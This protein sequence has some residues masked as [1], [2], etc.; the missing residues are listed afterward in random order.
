MTVEVTATSS[1][2]SM[3][4]E[5]IEKFISRFPILQKYDVKI[6]KG[7]NKN[8][9]WYFATIDIQ[10]LKDVLEIMLDTQEEVV[11]ST[12]SEPGTEFRLEIYDDY[13]E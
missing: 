8:R 6:C 7:G 1:F 11:L 3:S 12:S 2:L 4:K 5:G 13:R 10:T 9:N